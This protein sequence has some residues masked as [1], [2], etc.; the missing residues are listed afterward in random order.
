MFYGLDVG[1]DKFGIDDVNV[2]LRVNWGIV[3]S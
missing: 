3:V 2:G 1:K